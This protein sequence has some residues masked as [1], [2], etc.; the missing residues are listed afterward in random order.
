[1]A[2][3]I[4]LLVT[5][6]CPHA[7]RARALLERLA[8]EEGIP[9]RVRTI[10]VRTLDDAESSDFRGSPT[11][12]VDGTDVD[13][14][15]ITLPVNLGCRVYAGGDGAREGVPAEA[16]IRAALKGVPLAADAPSGDAPAADGSGP[17]LRDVPANVSRAFFLWASRSD[18]LRRLATATP[19]TRGLVARFVAGETL[20][21]ALVA[22]A[23]LRDSGLRTTV[24]VLGE[25][26]ATEAA[27]RDGADR[28]IETLDALAPE[29]FDGNVSLKLTQMGLD[30]DPAFCRDNVK[31]ILDRARATDAFVRIDM[32]DHTRTDATLALARDLR[33]TYSELGV[34][35]QSYLRRSAADVGALIAE[36]TRVRLC[37]GAYNEPATV[38]FATKTEVDN[39]YRRLMERLLLDGTY[40]AIATHDDRLIDHAR[41]F[42]AERG[43]APSRF[44][45]Q[46]L[47]G[48]RRDLQRRLVRD[49]Y[50]VR[51]YVPYGAEWYPYFMRRLAERPANVLFMLR[52]V[53]REG[54]DKESRI[55]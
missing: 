43:I 28:Y 52:S 14:A 9:G 17:D 24:D 26:V 39:S 22:L 31:R 49:G 48:V 19:L 21:E 42:T 23:R 47:Y 45:F 30:I 15:G 11:I 37:K 53:L 6:D 44:E 35:I 27:A 29:G 10:I 40:P 18:P 8:A 33:A 50:T 25:S 7:G 1:M 4:E 38:A 46:M 54:S 51:V 32:E 13:P 34:V 2:Q 16:R 12:R 41:R 55:S 20:D 3:R 36:R 5:P